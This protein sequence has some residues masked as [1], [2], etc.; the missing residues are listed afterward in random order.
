MNK[1]QMVDLKSQYQKIKPEIDS[2]IQAVIDSTS[3][4]KGG[5]VEEFANNLADFL[6]VKHVIACGNGT[7]ALQIAIMSLG[8]KPS[9][10]IICPSFTFIASA[11]VIGLLGF[12]PVFVDV[13][14]DSFNVTA[15]NIEKAISVK[16]KAIIPVHLFG[17]AA[18]MEEILSIAKKYDLHVIEDTA[19]AIGADY[20]FSN[21]E[22]KKLGTIGTIGC[23]SFF[24]SKNLGCF[25]DGGAIMTND[26][27]LAEKMKMIANHGMKVRYHHKVLGVNSRLDSIQAAILNVKL[28]HLEAY[29][30]ARYKAAQI[31]TQGLKDIASIETPVELPYSTHVYHQYT[32]KIT[33]GTRDEL[34]D[35]LAECGI[36]AMVYY[37]IALHQQEAFLQIAR[38]GGDLEVSERLSETVL[39]LPMHTELDLE[40]QNYIIEKIRHFYQ[41]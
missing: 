16:T 14:Y 29:Q 24:P 35:Y 31:Y 6:S 20:T 12:R 5:I 3:F 21:G 37:P 40:Q 2:S 38:R 39:S 41:V 8:L 26:D 23:T 32:L 15:K 34:K 27:V 30:D 25:G 1:I 18:P 4:I 19:Q 11:E 36:P 17:Q 7:D 33:D 13:D 10:E 28:K 22:K 9:D